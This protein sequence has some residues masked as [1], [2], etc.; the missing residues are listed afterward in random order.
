MFKFYL[1]CPV[2]AEMKYCTPGPK[3]KNWDTKKSLTKLTSIKTN[4]QFLK[5]MSL[6][7]QTEQNKTS[8]F[9][10]EHTKGSLTENKEYWLLKPERRKRQKD[11]N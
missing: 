4:T 9:Y 8:T 10:K 5:C 3:Y 11:R 7:D 1:I 6:I 2:E